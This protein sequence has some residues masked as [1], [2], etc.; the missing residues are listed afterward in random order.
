[1]KLDHNSI[2]S[3]GSA[4]IK[5]LLSETQHHKLGGYTVKG[6]AT[7]YKSILISIAKHI[8]PV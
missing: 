2:L 4:Q 1:M 5:W 8:K 3:G 7:V 6:L